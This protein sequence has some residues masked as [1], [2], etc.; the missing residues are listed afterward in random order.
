MVGEVVSIGHHAV[1][2]LAFD[3][4]MPCGIVGCF[5]D[6]EDPSRA[7]PVSMWVAPSDRRSG[8]GRALVC[9]VADWARTREAGIVHLTVTC[10]ND[11]AI[12]FYRS[13]GFSFTGGTEP[14]PN[15]PEL[16]EY[17]MT[18]PI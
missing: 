10:N 18:K 16:F 2:F 12:K 6:R 9:A 15:D 11:T 17:A 1:A 14:Y 7:H 8:V 4:D 13:L 3:A 5:L